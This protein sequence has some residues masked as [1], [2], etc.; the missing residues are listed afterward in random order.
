MVGMLNLVG[1]ES[2]MLGRRRKREG[3]E[4]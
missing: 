3:T 4:D 1:R 2:R